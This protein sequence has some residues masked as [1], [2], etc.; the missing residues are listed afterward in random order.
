MAMSGL[1]AEDVLLA[2]K[3]LDE[4]KLSELAPWLEHLQPNS[5]RSQGSNSVE[6]SYQKNLKEYRRLVARALGE[7]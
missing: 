7:I 6:T 4:R 5:G 2:R 3:W 1:N